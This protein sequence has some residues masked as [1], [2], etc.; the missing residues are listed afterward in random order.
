MNQFVQTTIAKTPYFLSIALL[1]LLFS[2]QSPASPET[3]EPTEFL[4]DGMHRMEMIVNDSLVL[5]FNFEW[6]KG[7]GN[8]S[9]RIYNAS[10]EIEV[11]E[12]NWQEGSDTLRVQMPVF[13]S[14]FKLARSEKGVEGFWYNPDKDP[15]YRVAV[16]VVEGSD[17]R[18]D[19][20]NQAAFSLNYNWKVSFIRENRIGFGLGEFKLDG[21]K[22]SGSILTETGDYRFLEGVLDGDKLSFST[23][24]GAHAYLFVARVIGPGL[25]EGSYFSGNHFSIPWRAERD[26]AFALRSATELNELTTDDQSFPFSFPSLDGSILSNEDE[27]FK[28]KAYIVQIMGSWCPN[29]MDETRFF[30]ALYSEYQSQGL[31]IVGITFERSGDMEKARPAMERMIKDLSIQYPVLFGGASSDVKTSLPQID[32]FMSFPTS[33]FVDRNGKVR[34][35]HTGFSGPGTSKFEAYTAKTHQLIEELL[36]E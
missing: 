12:I 11:T 2:C 1:G 7:D 28:G 31:E 4:A 25:M 18:F 35:I 33:F 36:E 3:S 15:K 8:F 26:D 34:E 16:R 10:E 29:C 14:Y 27:R 22:V 21:Q 6:K 5:P 19:V 17:T 24:D 20:I 9:M 30:N 23:F 32:T 13:L